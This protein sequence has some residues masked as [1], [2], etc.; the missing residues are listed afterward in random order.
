M[1]SRAHAF[2]LLCFVWSPSHNFLEQFEELSESLSEVVF[3]KVDVDENPDS[4][5]FQR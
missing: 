5:L 3:V 2:S 1:P 4:K